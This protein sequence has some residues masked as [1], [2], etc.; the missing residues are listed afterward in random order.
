MFFV[1]NFYLHSMN[2]ITLTT[3]LGLKDYYSAVLKGE[4]LKSIPD[5]YIV[6]ITHEI[7]PF[8]YSQAAF[9]LVNSYLHFPAGTIHL[10]GVD[11]SRYKGMNH[12]VLK[13]N[14]HFFIGPDNGLFSLMFENN[15]PKQIYQLK[16]VEPFN[17]L[18]VAGLYV[19]TARALTEG[20]HPEEIGLL[21]SSINAAASFRPI[22]NHNYIKGQVVHID[23][24]ENVIL[25][26]RKE[27][28]EST[29]KNRKFIVTFRRN[30]DIDK[31]EE[32]YS[33]IHDGD[34]SCIVN[35]AGYIELFM[36]H[37]A[38]ASLLG[39]KLNDSVQ[40]EFK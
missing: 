7:E 35:S 1:R 23:R 17:T 33:T 18:P 12:L 20:K 13:H 11:T 19:Q 28:F 29:R 27:E 38:M 36:K 10:V 9:I 16:N 21:V 25:N 31:L 37:G 5:I 39:L 32:N 3:D 2:L 6:D 15:L 34:I 14:D 4:L 24:F 30:N 22:I 26:V 40:I 8:S